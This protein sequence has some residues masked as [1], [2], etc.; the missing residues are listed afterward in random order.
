MAGSNQAVMFIAIVCFLSP[1][2]MEVSSGFQYTVGDKNGWSVPNSTME[3]KTYSQW[4]QE[5]RFQVGDTLLFVYNANEDSVVQVSSADDFTNCDNSQAI[6]TFKDGHTVFNLSHSGPFY[7]ISGNSDNCKKSEKIHVIV[8]SMRN[9]GSKSASPAPTPV[10]SSAL[11]PAP[12]PFSAPS[13][14]PIFDMLAPAPSPEA[15]PPTTAAAAPT[16]QAC[17]TA[18]TVLLSTILSISLM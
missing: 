4:A 13:P 5:K 1:T 6:A 15:R 9:H 18:L 12:T 3:T 16:F 8:M 14:A 7:F 10:S 17:G 2:L 11:A